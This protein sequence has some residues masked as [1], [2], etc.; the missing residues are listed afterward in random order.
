[1]F[2]DYSRPAI[3]LGALMGV[4]VIHVMTHDSIGVGEDGPTHQ[5][6]EHLASL[7]AMPNL[8]VFRPADAVEAAECWKLA[9]ELAQGALASWRSR[10][11]RSR[12]CAPRSRGENLSA[13]GAYQL[14]RRRPS[15]PGH[16]LRLRH[17]GR[18]R[19]GRARP[20]GGR[21]HRRPRGLDALLG[22]VRRAARR[23]PGRR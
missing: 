10:A 22:A 4:R 13:R 15:G 11:R 20:A 1:M 19:H 7:R 23:L 18:R 9:L 16:D 2:S 21:G 3:R 17:R 6:V 5:P 12:R 14:R 8:N